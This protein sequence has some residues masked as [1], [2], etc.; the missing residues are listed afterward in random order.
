MQSD[1]ATR[2]AGGAGLLL[3]PSGDNLVSPIAQEVPL[4]FFGQLPSVPSQSGSSVVG[5]SVGVFPFESF[6][7]A[8]RLA[9]RAVA[10]LEVPEVLAAG[11]PL[12]HQLDKLFQARHQGFFRLAL[13]LH[14]VWGWLSLCK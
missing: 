13:H 2:W 7:F 12:G 1:T 10:S 6:S 3:F 4:P 9:S 8:D 14:S 5:S 11:H